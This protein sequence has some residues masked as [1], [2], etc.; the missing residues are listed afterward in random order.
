MLLDGNPRGPVQQALVE[1][2]QP[3]AVVWDVGAHIG[4]FTLLLSRLVGS[5]GVV[6][7]FE[8]WPA[9]VDRLRMVST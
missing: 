1:I 5:S 6:H 3:G 9:N 2:V 8:P 7:A 4:F